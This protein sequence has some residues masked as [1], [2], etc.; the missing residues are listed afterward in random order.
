MEAEY[1]F[2]LLQ[3]MT[4]GFENLFSQ[5]GESKHKV[6]QAITEKYNKVSS[7]YEEKKYNIG[8][9]P[10]GSNAGILIR[11]KS[12]LNLDLTDANVIQK[13]GNLSGIPDA[14]GKSPVHCGNRPYMI[15]V[16]KKEKIIVI[17]VH[18]PKNDGGKACKDENTHDIQRTELAA[19]ILASA[20]TEIIKQGVT[21][22]ITW[23]YIIC[24]DFNNTNPTEYVTPLIK[25]ITG[26][27]P[28]PPLVI[29]QTS[30]CEG[31][32]I[33][34]IFT[35][36]GQPLVPGENYNVYVHNLPVI[37]ELKRPYFSDHLPVY[38]EIDI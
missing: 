35:N 24:G 30:T 11:K 17:N 18:Y 5:D 26:T 2:I 4:F 38:A 37:S 36:F 8:G 31:R 10:K 34:H 22:D 9:Q 14:A 16:L 1:D 29:H 21:F 33:D 32:A 23:K 19:R 28:V 20:M 25:T 6:D 13:N 12:P 3:E 15:L 27:N 7:N